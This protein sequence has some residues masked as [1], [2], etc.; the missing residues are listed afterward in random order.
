MEQYKYSNSMNVLP[1]WRQ[2][3]DS[4]FEG[5]ECM[6]DYKSALYP[7][8]NASNGGELPLAPVQ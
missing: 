3:E 1:R 8:G 6:G 7:Q 5:E 4:G 2:Q